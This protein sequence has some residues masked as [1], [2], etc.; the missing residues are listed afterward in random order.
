MRTVLSPWAHAFDEFAR[1]IQHKAIVVSPYITEQPLQQLSLAICERKH[2]QVTFL[3]NLSTDSILQG[4]LDARSIA[5]F[6]KDFPDTTVRHLPGLHAKA[7]VADDHTAIITS[8]N[9]TKSSLYQNYEY[10]VQIQDP[11]TVKKIARDLSDYGSLGS[12]IAFDD[13]SRLADAF[14]S[15]AQKHAD[16]LKSA[17]ASARSAFE[18]ELEATR[19]SLRSLRAAPGESA[20]SIFCRTILYLLANE[21]LTTRDMH[22]MIASIHPDLCDDHIDRIIN[23]VHFGREWKHRV[24]G[25][26]VDLRRKDLI[27]LVEGKWRLIQE[28]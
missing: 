28:R 26:Q 12:E 6:C 3:T 1:S 23:G 14:E 22:P 11:H 2:P 27:Y 5:R 9:L 20:N 13:L 8:G 15:L 18:T 4:S 25:A 16:A 21:P 24:R 7:Y 17:R 19:E 10:G